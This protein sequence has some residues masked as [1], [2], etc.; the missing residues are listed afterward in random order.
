MDEAESSRL[1]RRNMLKVAAAGAAGTAAWTAP[2]IRTLG[3]KPA[4]AQTCS[5]GATTPIVVE[6]LPSRVGCPQPSMASHVRLQGSHSFGTGSVELGP[7]DYAVDLNS[8]IVT[9]TTVRARVTH[10]VVIEQ[11]Q[12]AGDEWEVP[13]NQTC[14]TIGL[15]NYCHFGKLFDFHLVLETVP[16][17]E[18]FPDEVPPV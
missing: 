15:S 18:C 2:N 16:I 7:D 12:T 8:F 3:F 6:T 11:G 5:M 1:S 17:G 13:L 10:V 14:P 4:Y 9:S